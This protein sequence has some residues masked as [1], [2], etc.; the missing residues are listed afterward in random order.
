MKAQNTITLIII[1]IVSISCGKDQNKFFENVDV[2][3]KIEGDNCY[4]KLIAS[5]N[6]EERTLIDYSEKLKLT[7]AL[8]DDFNNDGNLDVLLENVKGCENS[9]NGY[10]SINTQGNSY[11]IF[12]TNGKDFFR[13]KEVGNDWG[14]VKIEKI[15]EIL[16]FTI[17]S[18]E[19]HFYKD[20]GDIPETDIENVYALNDYSLQLKS[21]R[22]IKNRNP[23]E[24]NNQHRVFAKNGL[25]I[26]DSPNGEPIGKLDFG[27][28]ITVDRNTNIELSLEDD[29]Y[30]I[31]GNWY[32]ITYNGQVG[33]VF[34]GFLIN[35]DYCCS[36]FMDWADINIGEEGILF[37]VHGQC[38]ISYPIKILNNNQIELIWSPSVDCKFSSG[39]WED[40]GADRSPEIG[41]PFA[42]YT[43]KNNKLFVEYYYPDWVKK[44]SN[45]EIF[46]SSYDINYHYLNGN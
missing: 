39:L 15:N 27:Q 25:I 6:G 22:F 17:D 20:K 5:I 30:R 26:R 36:L 46:R 21:T 10:Y 45:S 13:T 34:S 40:Y 28:I 24:E 18:T 11:F 19:Q 44:Y 16:H 2:S 31:D 3:Y 38:Y 7:I 42:K 35:T 12:S 14:G 33:Y 4:D 8:I 32:Q 29:D 37:R 23:K 9:Q 43:Y 41:K 1:L